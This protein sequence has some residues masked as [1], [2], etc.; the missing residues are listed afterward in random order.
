MGHEVESSQNEAGVLWKQLVVC[1][2]WRRSMV[3]TAGKQL[4][5]DIRCYLF[6]GESREVVGALVEGVGWLCGEAGWNKEGVS[7]YL[8]SH[9]KLVEELNVLLLELNGEDLASKHLLKGRLVEN[10]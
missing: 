4:W 2:T 1:A 8:N 9:L 3:F 7:V 10:A 5:N 6:K